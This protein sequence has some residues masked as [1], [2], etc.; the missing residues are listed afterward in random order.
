MKCV[1]LVSH[2]CIY[3]QMWF[4]ELDVVPDF[5]L[6]RCIRLL[7]KIRLLSVGLAVV[8]P[9][10]KTILILS[11]ISTDSPAWVAC[12]CH[13]VAEPCRIISAPCPA[14]SMLSSGSMLLLQLSFN[15]HHTQVL[16]PAEAGTQQCK[17]PRPVVLVHALCCCC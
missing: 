6:R 5:F 12:R 4:V 2:G 10:C 8:Q 9:R 17:V 3:V 15:L 14:S 13:R 16:Q 11:V 1:Q 7:L